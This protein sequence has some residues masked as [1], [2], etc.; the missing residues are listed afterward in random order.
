MG[1]L[2]T[3]SPHS[4]FSLVEL[5][6]VIIVIAILA[7][8]T[9]VAYPQI[10]NKAHAESLKSDLKNTS[11]QI[12]LYQL[13]HKGN[14]PDNLSTIKVAQSGDNQLTY[15]LGNK[16]YCLSASRGDLQFHVIETGEIQEGECPPPITEE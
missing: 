7:T 13:A 14:F 15:V 12:T 10:T 5:I 1:T 16:S 2:H 6:I 4:G 3:K 11:D 8:L 9:I